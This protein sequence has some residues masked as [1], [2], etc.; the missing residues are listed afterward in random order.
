M[1]L[2]IPD[3]S[4][5]IKD[6][7][8]NFEFSCIWFE[9]IFGLQTEF[10]A[11]GAIYFSVWNFI[12]EDTTVY[13]I[14][15][16]LAKSALLYRNILLPYQSKDWRGQLLVDP[17]AA[18]DLQTRVFS[19]VRLDQILRQ[20]VL[21]AEFAALRDMRAAL[22]RVFVSPIFFTLHLRCKPLCSL[23]NTRPSLLCAASGTSPRG[24]CSASWP[25]TRRPPPSCSSRCF[26]VSTR[27]TERWSTWS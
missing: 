15:R 2:T 8:Q 5:F 22:R 6:R 24:S 12:S 3:I 26:R 7:D 21:F 23:S 20:I 16:I 25:W 4:L 14:S 19:K 18:E 17:A 10:L 11:R 13:F 1:C 9:N 27:S